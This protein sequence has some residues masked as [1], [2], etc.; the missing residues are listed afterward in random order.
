MRSARQR[1]CSIGTKQKQLRT[2]SNSY[3]AKFHIVVHKYM[4]FI[5]NTPRYYSLFTHKTLC[6]FTDSCTL[7]YN[8]YSYHFSFFFLNCN[9]SFV[10]LIVFFYK[11]FII[12]STL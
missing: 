1:P 11:N 12:N 9:L 4:I 10:F 6:E 5:N 2:Y 8:L 3:H 7:S